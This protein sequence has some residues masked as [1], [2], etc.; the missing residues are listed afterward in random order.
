MESFAQQQKYVVLNFIFPAKAKEMNHCPQF[1][2]ASLL[3]CKL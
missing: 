3:C 1:K 2:D